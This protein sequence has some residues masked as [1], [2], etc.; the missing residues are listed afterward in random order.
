MT[1][2]LRYRP[3]AVANGVHGVVDDGDVDGLELH[4][5]VIVVEEHREGHAVCSLEGV[6]GVL[7][8]FLAF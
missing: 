1:S 7:F 8:G 5:A 4:L 3:R 2:K 6:L